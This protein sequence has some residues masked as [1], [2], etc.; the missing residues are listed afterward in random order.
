MKDRKRNNLSKREVHNNRE[1]KDPVVIELN[2]NGNVQRM[3]IERDR[4]EFKLN[5]YRDFKARVI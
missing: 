4:V 2:K 3:T 1:V 5:K